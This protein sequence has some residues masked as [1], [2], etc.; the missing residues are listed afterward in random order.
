MI[1]NVEEFYLQSDHLVTDNVIESLANYCH[2]IKRLSLGGSF[3]G[4]RLTGAGLRKVLRATGSSL[5]YLDLSGC[6]H[7]LLTDKNM[8]SIP[9]FCVSLEKLELG[10]LSDTCI[11]SRK[12][13]NY[14]KSMIKDVQLDEDDPY[15]PLR[16]DLSDSSES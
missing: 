4:N 8:M 10:C 16:D 9:N 5:K 3:E 6:G 7:N 15:D 12:C 11:Y 14:L 1:K 13:L 2:R